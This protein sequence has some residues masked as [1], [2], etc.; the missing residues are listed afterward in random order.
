MAGSV[1][2]TLGGIDATIAWQK[3]GSILLK[4]C[5]K[6]VLMN[7]RSSEEVFVE[8]VISSEFVPDSLA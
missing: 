5:K 8:D 3:K 2:A 4:I 1:V 7:L 6:E